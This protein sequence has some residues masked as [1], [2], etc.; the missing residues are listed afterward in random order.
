MCIIFCH[1]QLFTNDYFDPNYFSAKGDN[2]LLPFSFIRTTYDIKQPW[3]V[4]SND[5]YLSV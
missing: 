1:V 2:V 5:N 4:F 3:C